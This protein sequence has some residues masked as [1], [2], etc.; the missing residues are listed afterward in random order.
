MTQRG[1]TVDYCGCWRW[2]RF[3]VDR[4]E[5]SIGNTISYHRLRRARVTIFGVD[6]E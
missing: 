5:T 4:D 2:G 3:K 6:P 1:D